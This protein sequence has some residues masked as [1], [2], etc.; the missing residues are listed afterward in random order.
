MITVSRET[1]IESRA[2]IMA[3]RLVFYAGSVSCER[4]LPSVS[5]ETFYICFEIAEGRIKRIRREPLYRSIWK[6]VFGR[7]VSRETIIESSLFRK[8]DF[9]KSYKK[10]TRRYKVRG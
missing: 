6:S 9:I 3:I 8:C 2:E 7:Y 4:L 5:R 1:V 10:K